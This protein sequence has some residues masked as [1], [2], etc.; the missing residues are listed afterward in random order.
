MGIFKGM[1]SGCF[2]AE[3]GLRGG[4]GASVAVCTVYVGSSGMGFL[5]A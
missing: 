2:S 4:A 1:E 3:S 5:A